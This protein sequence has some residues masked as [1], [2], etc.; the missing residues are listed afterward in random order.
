[1]PGQGLTAAVALALA[2][3]ACACSPAPTDATQKDAKPMSSHARVNEL[4]MAVERLRGLSPTPLGREDQVAFGTLMFKY[5]A[6]REQLIAAIMV[7]DFD[8]WN[9]LGPD[10]AAKY[11]RSQA[12]LSD[13][14]IGG[15]FDS[16]GGAWMFE[17][18]TG[19]TYLYRSFPPDASAAEVNAAIE[20]MAAV[21]PAWTTRWSTAVAEIAHGHAPPPQRPVTLAD[22]P[23]AG[24]L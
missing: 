4:V 14:A 6:P 24:R 20:R 11:K 1:M 17:E 18:A 10:R 15:R 23:Y 21:V 8:L 12:A 7:E 16:G 19:R 2:A 5:L 9:K 22:D 13:P 3:A